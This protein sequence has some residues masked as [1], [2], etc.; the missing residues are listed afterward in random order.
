MKPRDGNV[1]VDEDA[2]KARQEYNKLNAE[3]FKKIHE[4][5]KAARQ[6]KLHAKGESTR[7]IKDI[8]TK[9]NALK[10]DEK[11]NDRLRALMDDLKKRI[12]VQMSLLKAAEL[13]KQQELS[14]IENANYTSNEEAMGVSPNSYVQAN[15]MPG[16][17]LEAMQSP[18]KEVLGGESS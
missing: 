13:K 17:N 18:V 8:T 3:D 7:Y 10:R 6:A 2:L 14:F 11:E 15:R 16:N 1:S 9:E 12:E 5:L 4:D